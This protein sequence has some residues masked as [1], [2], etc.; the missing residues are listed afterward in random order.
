[1]ALK[2]LDRACE[3]IARDS[4]KFAYLF[5]RRV[6]AIAEGLPQHPLLGGV[7]PEYGCED[8]RE[9]LFQNHRI[10]YR[11]AEGRVEIVAII[12]AARQMPPFPPR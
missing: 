7:V 6:V 3:Y 10:V 12:H 5:A 9:R 2:D 1:M 8:L 11:V 4:T